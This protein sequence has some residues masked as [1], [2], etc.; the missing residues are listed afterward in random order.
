MCSK[1]IYFFSFVLVLSLVGNAAGQIATNPIPPDGS[2]TDQTWVGLGWTPGAGAVS[3]NVYFGDNFAGV[4]DGTGGTFRGNF[5]LA[6]FLVGFVGYPYPEGLALGTTYYWR[7]DEVQADGT[8]IEGVVWS[9]TVIGPAA[10]HPSPPDGSRFIDLD[11]QLSWSPGA[12]AIMHHMYFGANSADVDA[13]TADTDKGVVTETTYTPALLESGTTYY[14]RVDEFDGIA[15]HKGDIWSFKTRPA[16]AMLDP[17]LVG[18]WKLDDDG[19]GTVIDYSGN[20]RDGTLH[21]DPQFVPGVDGDALEF[22]GDDYVTIDGYKGVVGDGTDTPPFSITAWVRKEG[23]TGGDGEIVGWG[24]TGAGNRLE[25]RFNAGNNRVRIESGGG[26]IQGDVALTAGEWTHVAVTLEA[27]STYTSDTGVNFYFDGLLVNRPNSD[28]DPIHPIANFDVIMGQ[29]YNQSN[30]R[31]FIGALDDVRIY[32]RVL[33]AEEVG[34]TMMGDPRLAWAQSPADQSEPFIEEAIL[35]WTPGDTAAEHDVYLGVSEMAVLDADISDTTGIY[36]GRQDANS[37]TPPETLEFAE[38]YYWRIDEV[39]ADGTTIH[40]GRVLSFTIANFIVVDNFEDYND[41]SPNEIFTA[42]I[43]GFFDPANGSQVGYTNAPFAE[44]GTVH[45]GAQAMPY[46]YDNSAGF[47]EATMT[48]SSVR[49]WTKHGVKALSLWFQGYPVSVGSFTQE[50]TGTYTMTVRSGDI[51]GTSDEFHFAYQELTG[52]GSIIA[53]VERVQRTNN[54]AQ[55]GV[56]IRDT[57]DSNS[58]HAAVVVQPRDGGAFLRRATTVDGTTTTADAAM[59]APL[60][61]KVERDMAGNVMGSY[62]ADGVAWTQLGGEI[63]NMSTPMY[64]GLVVA[65]SHAT[66]TCEAIFSD[67]QITG[68]TGQWANQDIG[69][70]ANDPAPPMYVALANR[71]GTPAVVYH[72]DPDAAQIYTWTQWNIDLKQFADQGV[73]LTDVNS[74]SIGFGDKAN[75]QPGGSGT[76]YFD[77]IRLYR[78]RCMLELLQPAGD[79]NGDCIVA[80]LDLETMAADWLGWH[81]TSLTAMPPIVPAA[82]TTA[83]KRAARPMWRASSARQSVSTGS[84]TM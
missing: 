48:L 53:K 47:S 37:Y 23:P 72:D 43:D 58:A 76:M 22:D 38:T 44:T 31:W 17:H 5:T 35:S 33:T 11:V 74:I 29:Q 27:N 30:S 84:T 59:A 52:A 80:C 26:N 61:L 79:F 67:V 56:M 25:F 14:W 34:R 39:E 83:P 64:I 70:L 81:I 13:G 54:A 41:W 40:T 51:A 12:G 4:R 10:R 77:D 2:E 65:S 71:G 1:L 55:A 45:W 7:V 46:F 68:A 9:F 8:I 42:W 6:T 24:S 20:N 32:N 62:S 49:D 75:P 63:I 18:W 78:P 60:W 36:R 19:T 69:I 16:F 3:H 57:L 73:N 82:T 15:T 21:G 28:P 50:P 66:R